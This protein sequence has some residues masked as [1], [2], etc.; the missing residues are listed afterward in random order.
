[1]K[2]IPVELY[3]NR[4]I[5][6]D[7]LCNE[8]YEDILVKQTYGR[9]TPWNDTDLNLEGRT[10]TVNDRKLIVRIPYKSFPVNADK[11]KISG[12]IYDISQI[13]DLGKF[14]LVCAVNRKDEDN[15]QFI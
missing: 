14:T 2:W 10:I 3:S 13:T 15:E 6:S 5:G 9:I 4:S 7:E 1:M 8:E 11:V 12:L